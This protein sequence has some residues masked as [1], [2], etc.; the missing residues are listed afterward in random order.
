MWANFQS[1]ESIKAKAAVIPNKLEDHI[2]HWFHRAKFGCC[3]A[4]SDKG[5]TLKA[6]KFL[7]QLMMNKKFYDVCPLI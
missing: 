7:M 6:I 5:S 2:Q 1:I 3:G 4:G